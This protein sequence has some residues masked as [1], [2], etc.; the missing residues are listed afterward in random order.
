MPA[1]LFVL[2]TTD[3]S[4]RRPHTLAEWRGGGVDYAVNKAIDVGGVLIAVFAAGLFIRFI[5]RRGERWGVEARDQMQNGAR[6]Q[7]ARTAAKLIRNVGRAVLV[8]V[9]MLMVLNQFDVNISPLLAR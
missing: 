7:R 9:A 2:Q 5:A 6:E 3:I 4:A 8:V 1:P